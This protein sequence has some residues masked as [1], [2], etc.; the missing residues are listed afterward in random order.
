[1]PGKGAK[2]NNYQCLCALKLMFHFLTNELKCMTCFKH[3]FCCFLIDSSHL[4]KWQAGVCTERRKEKPWLDS[5]DWGG[6]S[7]SGTGTISLWLTQNVIKAML[8]YNFSMCFPLYNWKIPFLFSFQE[9]TCEGELCKQIYKRSQRSWFF[10]FKLFYEWHTVYS[11]R[12]S[13]PT[14]QKMLPTESR[15][16]WTLDILQHLLRTARW[17][18]QKTP[19]KE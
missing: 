5:L 17:Q 14:L 3:L 2:L 11:T 13:A 18:Y 6:W 15:G 9:L 12:L 8:L 4:G 19:I 7:S 1:M 10:Q 16:F